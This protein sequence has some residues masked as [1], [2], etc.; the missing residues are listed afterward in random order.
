MLYRRSAVLTIFLTLFVLVLGANQTRSFGQAYCALRDPT[1]RIYDFYPEATSY[2]SL[3]RTVDQ[4]VRQYVSQ[5]LPFT[6]HFN[7][8]GRHTLYLPVKG[9]QP[10]GLIHA[11]SEAGDWGLSEIV[12]SLSPDLVIQDFE[13][14]RCRSRK[15]TEVETEAFKR[16]LI[17]KDF[18]QLRSLLSADGN[19]IQNGQVSVSAEA[20][21]L[22]SM[23]IRSALKTIAVTQY[24]W[25][26]ELGVIQPLFHVNRAFPE[27]A[28]IEKVNQPYSQAV[29]Q[30]YQS[31]FKTSSGKESTSIDRNNVDVYKSM[32]AAGQEGGFVVRTPWSMNGTSLN[33][34][35]YVRRDGVI[36][37]VTSEGGWPS[38]ETQKAFEAVAGLAT[39]QLD[40]CS[41]AAQ[42]AGAEVLLL[43]RKQGA[44]R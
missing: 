3:V 35:W 18:Q 32:S 33:L 37:K 8:L 16:Q 34:W 11:R 28:K 17:G 19:T 39:D 1:T 10:M 23:V 14:Q 30:A 27:T 40:K 13:F 43:V 20:Q 4:E 24:T 2:R 31:A 12:W 26:R 38:A 7:E 42:M 22:A 36:A 5:H 29:I 6:I 15:R 9:E 44:S 25:K 21:E 41:T